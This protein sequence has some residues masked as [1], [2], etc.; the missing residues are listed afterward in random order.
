M[1]LETILFSKSVYDSQDMIQL[2]KIALDQVGKFY[3]KHATYMSNLRQSCYITFTAC[4]HFR[5]SVDDAISQ[6]G[7]QYRVSKE[8]THDNISKFIL[9]HEP[10]LKFTWNA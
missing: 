7:L 8:T 1:Y 2:K 6:A 5:E 3:T 4:K 9:F 10:M